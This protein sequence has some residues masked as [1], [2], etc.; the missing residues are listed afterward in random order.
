MVQ[1]VREGMGH[2]SRI[3]INKGHTAFTFFRTVFVIQH[4]NQTF[5][6]G[7]HGKLFNITQS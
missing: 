5:T 4:H 1:N 6:H 3:Y 2:F 7:R